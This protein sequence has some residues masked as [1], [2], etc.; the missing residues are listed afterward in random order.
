[1]RI[2][3]W[4]SDVCSSDLSLAK[5]NEWALP[6]LEKAKLKGL[7]LPKNLKEAKVWGI[8]TYRTNTLEDKDR[9]LDIS[10]QNANTN[11]SRP[12]P[13]PRADTTLEYFREISNIPA[14]QRTPEQSAF[15]KKYTTSGRG[16]SSRTG[17]I[18]GSRGAPRS[19]VG[20]ALDTAL[21]AV[22]AVTGGRPGDR[23]SVV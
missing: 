21:G 15:I 6:Y 20:Q 12:T 23:K 1:M 9:G 19:T 13:R 14:D 2:S 3:D 10:Q 11:A 7:L 17:T 22:G 4:S 8:D 18:G 16:G 5:F